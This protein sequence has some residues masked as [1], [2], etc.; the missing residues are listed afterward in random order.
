M[1]AQTG[2]SAPQSWYVAYAPA[3][4][5]QIAIAVLVTNS[6]EGSEVAAPIVRRI[7]DNYFNESA[8]PFPDW[9]TGDYIQLDPPAG[10]VGN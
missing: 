8:A 1:Q 4:N 7:L 6:R 2:A 9:W 10:V 3:D 5:P